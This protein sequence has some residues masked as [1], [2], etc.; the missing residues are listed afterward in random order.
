MRT[1]LI[2]DMHLGSSAVIDLLRRPELRRALW[3]EV[4]GANQVVLLG[5]A[6]ELRDRPLSEALAL[7][8]PFFAELAS[9][10]GGG[11]VLVVPGNHDHHLLEGWLEHRRLVAEAPLGLEQR[12]DVGAGPPSSSPT[13]GCG[14]VP[15]ST[16]PT[17][18]TSIGT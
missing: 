2:S 5:D 8:R 1:V 15:G 9:V 13:P 11:R 10:I 7:A 4:E 3:E 17:A 6:I 16:P 18:T 12:V 14:C